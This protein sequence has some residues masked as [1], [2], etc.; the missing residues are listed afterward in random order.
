MARRAQSRK[1]KRAE[2]AH[3]AK[4]SSWGAQRDLP[5]RKRRQTKTGKKRGD[6][7][8]DIAMAQGSSV[9]AGAK[10]EPSMIRLEKKRGKKRCASA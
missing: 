3:E 6:W 1:R 2:A 7:A 5:H 9:S 10:R 4:A 8:A